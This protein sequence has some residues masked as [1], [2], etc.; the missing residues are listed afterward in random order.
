MVGI[1]YADL[2]NWKPGI[3]YHWNFI[4]E[5]KEIKLSGRH[6]AY[7][8]GTD[9]QVYAVAAYCPHMGAN[10]GVGGIVKFQSCIE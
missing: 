4:R 9:R 2:V 1:D 7:Y 6:I 8:R 5:V 10:L 3:K